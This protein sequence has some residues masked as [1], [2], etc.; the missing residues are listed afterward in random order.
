MQLLLTEI[1]MIFKR[2]LCTSCGIL[3]M[4]PK[5]ST[6]QNGKSPG[7]VVKLHVLQAHF[8]TSRPQVEY[9]RKMDL[10]TTFGFILAVNYVAW[11]AM[12]AR[13]FFNHVVLVCFPKKCSSRWSW[14]SRS[15]CRHPG[16][17]AWK[18]LLR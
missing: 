15:T 10:L 12:F 18:W 2:N 7:E 4:P 6:E 8:Q 11:F 14:N 1:L 9:S 16:N 17:L 5:R 3:E 13:Y